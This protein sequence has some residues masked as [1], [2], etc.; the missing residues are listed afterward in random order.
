MPNTDVETLIQRIAASAERNGLT[1]E[2][3]TRNP[4]FH[5]QP[6]ND[7]VRHCVTLASG[8]QPRTV[9]YGSEASNFTEVGRLVVLGPGDIRQAHK[10]D[11]WISLD[12][13]EQG[14]SVYRELLKQYC[15]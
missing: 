12:Q 6:N 4:A 14:E 15:Q 8:R 5:R 13:L 11:E 1:V 10:S 2:L 7:F 9:A 3:K